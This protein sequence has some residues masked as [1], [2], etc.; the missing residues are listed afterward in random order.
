M[1]VTLRIVIDESS[2]FGMLSGSY[3]DADTTNW[4]Q[5]GGS[6]HNNGDSWPVTFEIKNNV[7]TK[8]VTVSF[9]SA[10]QDLSCVYSDTF[11][12]DTDTVFGMMPSTDTGGIMEN[13]V[14]I[15]S[16]II[17]GSVPIYVHC[18]YGDALSRSPNVMNKITLNLNH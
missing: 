7:A 13:E 18:L 16:V 2:A 14:K 6:R 15:L 5:M 17:A 8:E 3:V 12:Q 1:D 4:E 10:T 11:D 9:K